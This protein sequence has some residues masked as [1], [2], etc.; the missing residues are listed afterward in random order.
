MKQGMKMPPTR[1][2]AAA[3][4][5]RRRI[6]DGT[7]AGGTQIRQDALAEE[8]GISR[9]PVREALFQLEAEGLVK[10][11]AH[12]GA[13][14]ATLSLDEIEELFEFRALIEPRL[15]AKS[16]PKLTVSDFANIRGILNQY[17]E[18]F[19]QLHV[20]R[21]GDLNVQLHSALYCHAES[22][23]M[24]ATAIQLLHTA[25]RFTRMQL[26]Y[27]D[28]LARAEHEH[29]TIVDLC[30]ARKFREATKALKDHILGAGSSLLS[31]L[32]ER[33][34]PTHESTG[35]ENSRSRLSR[36]TARDGGS[37]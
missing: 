24:L 27:T 34:L 17:S 25:D 11:E 5:L 8:F 26:S 32:R 15:L 22:P 28:G 3:D 30:E 7:Y 18:H 31:V 29:D 12:K 23:K 35:D 4:E 37:S 6:L 33:K 13:V 14:V 19:R 16:A 9:I 36:R 1:A 10:I 2:M 20:D 21:W